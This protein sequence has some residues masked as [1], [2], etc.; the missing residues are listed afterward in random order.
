[1]IK[2]HKLFLHIYILK[3]KCFRDKKGDKLFYIKICMKGILLDM[4]RKIFLF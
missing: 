3:K 2:T 4:E 1:M